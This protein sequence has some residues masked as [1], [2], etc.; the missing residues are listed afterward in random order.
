VADAERMLGGGDT[1]TVQER[2]PGLE[3]R[4]DNNGARG[5]DLS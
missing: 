3:P 1:E 4:P 5:D 2:V